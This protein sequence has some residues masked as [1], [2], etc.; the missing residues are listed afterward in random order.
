MNV[1]VNRSAGF[2]LFVTALSSGLMLAHAPAGDWPQWRG[3][4]RDARV[5]GFVAPKTWPTEMSQKWKVT[6][7]RGDATPAWVGDKI[8]VFVNDA[9]GDITLCCEAS[10]GK[11]LWRNK[12]DAQAATEPMGQHPGPRSSPAV[13]GGKIVAYGA[14]GTLSCL[15]V[16]T[17]KV[18]WRKDDFPGVWPRFFTSAS[19][20]IADHVVIAQLGSE[21][22]GGVVAY[23]LATGDQKWKW[24]AAGT[25]YASPALLTVGTTRMVVALT[26]QNI[27]GL[28]LADGKLLWELP[29]AAQ[30]R[31]YNAATPIVA[32][33]TVIYSGAGRG[34]RAAKIEK[35]GDGFSAKELWSNSANAV[36]YNTPVI[37]DG[38]LYGITQKGEL[39]CLDAQKGDTLW[40]A[41]LGG[42]GFG[43]IVDAGPALFALTPQGE[44]VA[45]EPSDKEFKKLGGYK[46]GTDTYAYPVIAGAGICIKDK[47]SLTL[48]T[49]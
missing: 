29:F 20:L 27:V 22:Q 49:F 30:E 26:A 43:S 19:P 4:G 36:Q 21:R 37:K 44:L 14:R 5:T 34:T 32:G 9:S 12:Y 23:D 17:G 16:A 31:A 8:Y 48:W 46:V 13:A 10:T 1:F 3:P 18:A 39:F 7:G 6:V 25:A 28:A 42:R 33:Q 47:D 24:T 45:F 35:A 40:T 11:E 38:Q 41:P 15:D 2:A